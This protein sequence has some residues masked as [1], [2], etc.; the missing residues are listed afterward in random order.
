MYF[1]KLHENV[2]FDTWY[3]GPYTQFGN[4]LTVG[5]PYGHKRKIRVCAGDLDTSPGTMNPGSYK[6]LVIE[7]SV[8]EVEKGFIESFPKLRDLI[9]EGDIQPIPLTPELEGLL[10]RNKVIVRG[11]FNSAA[12]K[13]AVRLGL[14]FFHK[15]LFVAKYYE[16][17]RYET[18][19]LMLCFQVGEAP[20]IW[21][22]VVCPGISAG[23]NGG[24]TLRH[25]LPADFYK[26]GSIEDFA[27]HFGPVY[28]EGILRNEALAAFLKEAD[29]RGP[30]AWKRDGH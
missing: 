30:K 23:N 21:E 15:N 12:E 14:P 7:D 1:S 26:G 16:E 28:T 9:V 2:T 5:A 22:D 10:K 6:T 11:S 3:P 20:F 29:R 8:C 25:D 13:L 19:T 18:T 27:G 24:G 4:V 17:R